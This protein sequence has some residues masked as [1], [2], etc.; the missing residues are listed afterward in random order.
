MNHGCK[1]LIWALLASAAELMET[2]SHA[3]APADPPGGYTTSWL[4][5][6]YMD[7]DGHKTVTEELADICVSPGGKLFTAGYAEAWGGGAEDKTTDAGFLARY[8]RFESGFGDPVKAVAADNNFVFWGTPGKGLLRSHQGGGGAGSYTTFL[9]GKIITG[10]FVKDGKLFVSNF[11]DGRIHVFDIAS[12]TEDRSWG[13]AKPTRLTVDKSGTVW[14]VRWSSASPQE[15]HAGSAWWGEKVVSFSSLGKAGSEIT[16]FE[17]PLA[18]AV[19][20]AGQLLIGGLNK[21]SQIWIYD[22]HSVPRKVGTFG[23]ENGIF[24]GVAGAFTTSAKL[25]WIKAIA[26]DD[27]DNIYTGCTYGTFWGNCVEKWSPGGDLQWRL[28]GGPSLDCGGVDPENETEVYSK[29]HHYSLN[30]ANAAPGTEWSLKGFTVNRFKYPDDPRIDQNSD[31][32]SRAL[33]AG[34]WRIGGKLFVGRSN[35]EGYRFELYRQ[36]RASDGE[37]L[38]PSFRLGTGE[39]KNNHFYNA[40]TKT[41]IQKPKKDGLYNQYWSIAKNGGLFSIG[42][43]Q[44]VIEYRFG[45][46][47]DNGNPIWDAA[48]ASV[49]IVSELKPIRRVVY[50]SD[51]DVMYLAGDVKNQ[52]WGLFLRIKSFPKW[53]TGN[54]SSSFTSDLPYEDKEYAGNSNYGG[55]SPLL[56]ALPVIT[57]SCS[58]E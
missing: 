12:M 48:N 14:V 27:S 54:R 36:E 19:N 53:S 43:P 57:F 30:Y 17:K 34:A 15:P 39:D 25:H 21:H 46:L 28:F 22:I 4:G 7:V 40:Q 47:D 29:Y 6:T 11:S 52:N 55:G 8:D 23:A 49:S 37:V 42:V 24:S 31:V 2:A 56:S 1:F 44:T 50:D 10:L 26:V 13:C 41:W 58:T 35:Q 51:L 20:K 45:G 32:G 18:L 9:P 5:N 3:E 38:V 16:E 33:G